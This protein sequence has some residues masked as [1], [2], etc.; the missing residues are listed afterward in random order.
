MS[1]ENDL[2]GYLKA[3][4]GK[5]NIDIGNQKVEILGITVDRNIS[6]N[7]EDFL[8]SEQGNLMLLQMRESNN[9]PEIDKRIA[10]R[11]F[12]EIS[13]RWL[14]D[15]RTRSDEVLLSPQEVLRLWGELYKSRMNEEVAGLTEGR[16]KGVSI[17]DGLI[18]KKGEKYSIIT[19][20][21]EYKEFPPWISP[22]EYKRIIDQSKR[23]RQRV[24]A[25]ELKQKEIAE[26]MG[27]ILS[28]IRG[29]IPDKPLIV[30]NRLQLLYVFPENSRT[31]IADCTRKNIPINTKQLGRLKES[32]KKKATET[33]V[34]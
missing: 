19:T 11:L 3:R 8:H 14:R 24:F 33:G 21:V 10:G 12:E 7:I 16:K 34:C 31:H 23:Y 15:Q 30:S 29:E 28:V 22:E 18:V 26:K 2:S 25:K 32:L 5:G 4:E 13:Y 17:P 20:V 1:I 6:N 27:R 9:D